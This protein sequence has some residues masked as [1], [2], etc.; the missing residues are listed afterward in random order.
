MKNKIIIAGLIIIILGSIGANVFILANNDEVENKQDDGFDIIQ[1]EDIA[2]NAKVDNLDITNVKIVTKNGISTY[3]ATVT[4]NT[5]NDVSLDKLYVVF[6]Q[7]KIENKILA[8]TDL[9]LKPNESKEIKILSEEE[10]NHST[11][12]EYVIE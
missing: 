6:Y 1:N 5:K 10:L 8:T 4:N 11:K 12:I 7:D 2:K 9:M 3:K